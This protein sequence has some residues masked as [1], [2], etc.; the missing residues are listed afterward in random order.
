LEPMTAGGTRPTRNRGSTVKRLRRGEEHRQE[1]VAEHH[2]KLTTDA[3]AQLP[4][5][6]T[7]R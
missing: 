7:G 1:T 3:M 6:H 5:L 4:P 2:R